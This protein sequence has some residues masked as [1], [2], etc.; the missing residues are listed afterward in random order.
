M[1]AAPLV[2]HPERGRRDRRL[3]QLRGFDPEQ[4]AEHGARSGAEQ[5]ARDEL[6]STCAEHAPT[7]N[8]AASP[9]SA[10]SRVCACSGAKRVTRARAP[11]RAG[12]RR[13]KGAGMF[14][15]LA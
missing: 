2:P 3:R 8:A 4:D 14:M 11:L 1:R 7:S 5:R 13:A 6:R 9:T 15:T 12:T 10:A